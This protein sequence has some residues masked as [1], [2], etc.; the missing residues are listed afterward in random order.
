[1][2]K[3]S[4]NELEGFQHPYEI[5]YSSMKSSKNDSLKIKA[6][7]LKDN[8]NNL[9]GSNDIIFR[10]SPNLNS[11]NSF[12][13]LQ[14]NNH[15]FRL[16]K[17]T[18]KN[19]ENY[20][21]SNKGK[22][23]KKPNKNKIQNNNNRL[24]K[25][26]KN[27]ISNNINIY[28][29]I[30]NYWESRDKK[31]KIKMQRIKKEREQKIYGELCPVPKISKNT[32]EIIERLKERNYELTE[33]DEYEE[34]INKNIPIK[35]REK[36]YFFRTVYYSNKNKLKKQNKINKSVSKIT[37]NYERNK[38][39]KIS[40]NK[41]RA[42]TP[43]LKTYKSM[44]KQKSLNKKKLNLSVADI[45]NLEMIKLIRKKEEDEKLL[46]LQEKIKEEEIANSP[47]NKSI[48]IKK[49]KEV[50]N[51]NSKDDMIMNYMNK[52]MNTLSM[53]NFSMNLN[54]YS[55]IYEIMTSR[56]YLND[57]YNKD[58]KIINHSFI[59]NSSSIPKS[60]HI[61]KI[62]RNDKNNSSSYYKKSKTL[63][64]KRNSNLRSTSA[65]SKSKNK[66]IKEYGLYDPKS[67][68]LRYRHY[69]E[70][71]NSYNNLKFNN[72]MNIQIE[73]DNDNNNDNEN[74]EK[75][76]NSNN[77]VINIIENPDN[78]EYSEIN[79]RYIVNNKLKNNLCFEFDRE[80]KEKDEEVNEI[81]KNEIKH[82]TN[83][84]KKIEI[85]LNERNMINKKLINEANVDD[86][87]FEKIILKNE[88]INNKFNEMNSESLLKFREE[89]L[90]KLA[91][92]RQKGSKRDKNIIINIKNEEEK[93]G[94]KQF[95][96]NINS[97]K[98]KS[99]L[100]DSQQQIENN[101]EL[102]NNEL[103]INDQK[104]KALLNKIFG[105]EYTKNIELNDDEYDINNAN[106][107]YQFGINKY[108]IKSDMNVKENF[109]NKYFSNKNN[110]EVEKND[111]EIIVDNFDFQRR[112][113]F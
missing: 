28:S 31:N 90:K 103:K 15:N 33:E 10:N 24:N 67:K 99:I 1:M 109:A 111:N 108:L 36:N 17:N 80:V 82:Q 73:N 2:N 4:T 106:N 3:Y 85:E 78:N 86:R 26:S 95:L 91:E 62:D 9:L 43:K 11:I 77:K 105:N 5:D 59:L 25:K 20:I 32:K 63:E 88:S 22:L 97:M 23:T 46:E 84:I 47:K 98:Y 7:R 38:L 51:N 53:R 79:K 72:P 56:K 19:L 54:N 93:N 66:E 48:N 69:T 61:N 70:I 44:K 12:K 71:S 42:K 113:H 27:K 110:N 34:E 55:N 58:K 74:E 64:N 6:N 83:E 16:N 101:L 89:N 60:S 65:A 8:K 37:S 29:K 18:K 81:Y 107:E 50:N 41:N 68:T 75:E 13:S 94:E 40:S 57:I 76:N 87:D 100:N 39:K 45:K 104:K 49:D 96:K 30:N 35:T 112:H 14:S 21:E 52:S 102:Y 92:L